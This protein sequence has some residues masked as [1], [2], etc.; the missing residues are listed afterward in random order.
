MTKEQRT[1]KQLQTKITELEGKIKDTEY[2]KKYYQDEANEKKKE[3]EDV[4]TVLDAM[5]V[6]AK[7]KGDYSSKLSISSR[8][9]L[10][11][12]MIGLQKEIKVTNTRLDD[13]DA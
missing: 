2:W 1:I 4:N 3:I 9:T 7:T 6:P 12:T 10:L 8:L 11:I 5:G 13:E